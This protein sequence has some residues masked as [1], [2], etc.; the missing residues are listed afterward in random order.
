MPPEFPFTI[1]SLLAAT[2]TSLIIL[3]L[4]FATSAVTPGMLAALILLITEVN[5]VPVNVTMILLIERL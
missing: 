1:V 2:T 4:L 3:S 5:E